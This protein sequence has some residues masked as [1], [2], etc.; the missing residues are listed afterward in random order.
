M[1]MTMMC[2]DFMCTLKLTRS[3]LSLAHSARV[4]TDMSEKKTK[5]SWSPMSQSG[6]WTVHTEKRM[7]RKV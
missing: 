2:N 5:N 1:M 6:G 4:K 3:Q 7:C